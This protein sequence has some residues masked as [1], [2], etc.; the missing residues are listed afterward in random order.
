MIEHL[1]GIVF[2]RT[3]TSLIVDVN[4]VGYGV[5][6]PLSSLCE[7][8]LQGESVSL[9]IDTYV[10]EDALKLYGFLTADD[11]QA[12]LIL[13]SVSG[14]G[15]KIALAVMSSLDAPALRQA[16]LSGRT[17]VLESVPGIGKRTAEKMILELRPKMEKFGMTV[18]PRSQK[19]GA[20]AREPKNATD[21]FDA[22]DEGRDPQDHAEAFERHLIDLRS[23]LENLGYKDKDINPIVHGLLRD[24]HRQA[25]IEFK[26]LLRNALKELRSGV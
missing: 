3:P 26:S 1:I 12:F 13:R 14:I 23:A 21:I 24:T 8:P 6:M 7:T 22:L 15:P 11:R 5:E 17:E 9:W 19:S 4:G 10:R 2:A 20:T 16:V 18:T 25:N